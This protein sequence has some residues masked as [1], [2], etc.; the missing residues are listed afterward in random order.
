MSYTNHK[1]QFSSCSI[2]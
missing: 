1:S 2:I